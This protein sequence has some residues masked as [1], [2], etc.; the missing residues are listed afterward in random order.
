MLKVDGEVNPADLFT[1]H[2]VSKNK[3]DQVV[4][5][6]SCRFLDG[7]AALAPTIKSD[8]AAHLAHDPVLMARQHLPEDIACMF[9]KAIADPPRRGE[10]DLDPVN[11]LGT[12]YPHSRRCDVYRSM[13]PDGIRSPRLV[14]LNR[15]ESSARVFSC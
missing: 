7:R 4:G 12:L 14:L 2:L 6:F 3:L 1:T 15:T 5:L 9:P 8:A 10:E 13:A 11:E